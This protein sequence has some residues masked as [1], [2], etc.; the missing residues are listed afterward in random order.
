MHFFTS[1]LDVSCTVCICD[2]SG[3][4]D[5]TVARGGHRPGICTRLIM[6]EKTKQKC[7]W[8]CIILINT[9][10]YHLLSFPKTQGVHW[11]GP[12]WPAVTHRRHLWWHVPQLQAGLLLGINPEQHHL[13][14]KR[15]LT[16]GDDAGDHAEGVWLQLRHLRGIEWH[17]SAV[18]K[19]VFCQGPNI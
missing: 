1:P 18:Q 15:H 6:T 5:A 7:C 11:V 14:W 13:W 17:E 10:K 2:Y 4:I 16:Q 12:E 8:F 3:L 9:I 19:S